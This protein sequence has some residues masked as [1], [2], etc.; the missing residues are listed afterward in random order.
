MSHLSAET[1]LFF[2]LCLAGQLATTGSV[3]A[4]TKTWSGAGENSNWQTPANWDSA[5]VAN[6]ALAFAGS[7]RLVNTNDFAAP[8]AFG[9]ITFSPGAG[10][11]T[12]RGN[13][14]TLAGDITNSSSSLQT[15]AFAITNATGFKVNCGADVTLSGVLS[16]AGNLTKEGSGVLTLTGTDSPA[17]GNTLVK[18]GTL[19]WNANDALPSGSVTVEPGA[20]FVIGGAV[21]NSNVNSRAYVIGGAGS[22]G[23]GAL[24]RTNGVGL[25]SP[26]GI[27]GLTLTNNATVNTGVRID[28]S[29]TVNLSSNTLTKIGADSLPI[30]TIL[31]APNAT[32][33]VAAGML[34]TEPNELTVKSMI[35]SNG[36]SYSMYVYDTSKTT[37][38][39]ISL[40]GN[41]SLASSSTPPFTSLAYYAGSIEVAGG[42]C[43]IVNGGISGRTASIVI[44]S[45]ISGSGTI[46]LD[47]YNSATNYIRF[48]SANTFGGDVQ[49]IDLG[50]FYLGH[51]LALQNAT[52][53]TRST[54]VGT[55]GFLTLTQATFGG[56]KGANGFA[57]TNA[58]GAAVALAVGNNNTNTTFGGVLSGS[59]SLTKIG[60]G[61]LTLTNAASTFSGATLVSSGTLR[62][63]A[64]ASLASPDRTISGGAT[65]K[66]DS[67]VTLAG[68]NLTIDAGGAG[69]P[70]LLDVT[71]NLTLGG[72]LTVTHG[73][74][75]QK[76]AQCT[77]TLSGDFDETS[78][79]KKYYLKTVGAKELWVI[80]F[81]GTCI[82]L[83]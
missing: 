26:Y 82:R 8:T 10:A 5:P 77:G 12:L 9:G 45:V 37:T 34:Y 53:D 1:A 46:I 76:I 7:V 33:V 19:L 4:A 65:L 44:N 78:M 49:L 18:A 15:I 6:D 60:T 51:A 11:F 40:F 62:V 3:Q 32:L 68:K 25:I 79:P 61:T 41:S 24:I 56:L 47:G 72:K 58:A 43:T 64:N 48:N 31:N 74:E 20:T 36:T 22:A 27:N 14:I 38:A 23:Q 83:Y 35:L 52:L 2:S 39:A 57:L 21:A 73:G 28:V 71:G 69:T 81:V 54:A 59:G 13:P 42:T 50:S 70:G 17:T 55:L 80:R 30:R 29:S 75:R 16:G 66:I 63:G 67:S